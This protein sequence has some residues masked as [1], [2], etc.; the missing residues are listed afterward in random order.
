MKK[1]TKILLWLFIFFF[2]S[3]EKL[4]ETATPVQ[5]AKEFE[6]PLS[7]ISD[8]A[9][10][11]DSEKGVDMD[12]IN[13]YFLSKHNIDFFETYDNLLKDEKFANVFDEEFNNNLRTF[14][15]ISTFDVDAALKEINFSDYAIKYVHQIV[16]LI[17]N[18]DENV[19]SLDPIYPELARL[20]NVIQND[21]KLAAHEKEYLLL[22]LQT[23]K[24]NA[25]GI[26]EL[27]EKYFNGDLSNAKT[28]GWLKKAWRKV[29][30]V[31]VSTITGAVAGFVSAGPV[32]AIIG[33]VAAL[34][35]TTSDIIFNNRC[36]FAMQCP[37]GWVQDCDTGECRTWNNP[38]N[39]TGGGGSVGGTPDLPT[40]FDCAPGGSC[41]SWTFSSTSCPANSRCYPGPDEITK[42]QLAYLKKYGARE[43]GELAEE[44][45]NSLK[46]TQAVTVGDIWEIQ[47]LIQKEYLTLKG[48]FMIAIP[49]VVVEMAKPFIEL[50]VL[51]KFTQIGFK[52]VTDIIN[53][54]YVLSVSEL[55]GTYKGG[56]WIT[57]SEAMSDASAAYQTF[58]TGRA[59]N[60]TYL[61][62]SVKFDGL[63]NGVLVDAKSG[64]QNFV[65]KNTGLFYPW[66]RGSSSLL[67]QAQRQKVAAQ[68]TRIIWHFENKIA[69]DAVQK[70]FIQNNVKGIELVFKP[71]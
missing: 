7:A 27:V 24:D 51:N 23:F 46:K 39:N 29:R 15:S 4:D 70:L 49:R 63:V 12:E 53:A 65:N 48:Q 18:E 1:T 67:A 22:G 68:G 66:F 26:T 50:A 14:N 5:K 17:P 38:P 56:K 16:D 25:E 36:S 59:A 64:Y 61:L 13:D 55:A 32:G 33:G 44:V 31:V 57:T 69:K 60:Q 11:I 19:E 71:K 58:I 28:N 45:Y 8:V 43:F 21:S 30:S 52:V 37:S 3:C 62:N 2:I 41:P 6:I 34:I 54:R 10:L 47:I 40:E 35:G 9:L 42:G 20:Q